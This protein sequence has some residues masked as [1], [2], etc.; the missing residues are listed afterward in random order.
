M[1]NSRFSNSSAAA[2]AARNAS[3]AAKTGA[4]A[5]VQ[6]GPVPNPADKPMTLPPVIETQPKPAYGPG[7]KRSGGK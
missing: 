4:R 7:T 6:R 3:N 2:Q 5:L 1:A